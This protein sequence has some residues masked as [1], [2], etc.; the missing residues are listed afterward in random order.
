[1]FRV[2]GFRGLG[3][4]IKGF[5]V[6]ALGFRDVLGLEFRAWHRGLDLGF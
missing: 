4:R 6:W 2:W 5:R 1:M 3:L